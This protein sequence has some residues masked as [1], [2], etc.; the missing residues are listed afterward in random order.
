MC[1]K[2]NFPLTLAWL[3]PHD[4]MYSPSLFTH[5]SSDIL[6][7]LTASDSLK[8]MVG[9]A[10]SPAPTSQENFGSFH[11]HRMCVKSVGPCGEHP[12]AWKRR[13]QRLGPLWVPQWDRMGTE[14][15]RVGT[16]L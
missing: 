9:F 13:V 12:F 4:L 10:T 1:Y 15:L 16:G 3:E 7:T 2:F 8:P 5:G 11:G 14:T 6:W